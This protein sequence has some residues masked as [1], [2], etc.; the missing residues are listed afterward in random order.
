MSSA[1]ATVNTN[2]KTKIKPDT[3]LVVIKV[4]S[5]V[6]IL[7]FSLTCIIPFIMMV[8]GSFTSYHY[9][10]QHGFS[11]IPHDVSFYAYEFV[12]AVPDIIIGDYVLTIALTVIGTA[13][14]LFL[15]AMTGYVLQRPDYPFRNGISFYIYFTTLFSGGL[16][17]YFI[18]I[19]NYLHLKNNY[20]SILLPALLSPWLII[21][22]KSFLKSVPHAITEAAIIDGAGDFKIFTSVI[23]PVS[24]PAL[25][26]IGLFIGLGYWNDW[27]NGLLFLDNQVRYQ[28]LQLFLYKVVNMAQFLNTSAAML[29]IPPQN[30]PGDDLKMAVAV[31]ATGPIIIV[32]PFVQKYFI[33]GLT[34]GAVKG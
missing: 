16:V 29:N 28:P 7:I 23:L 3:S 22:M 18:L 24:K 27:Y 10:L 1:T 32:Y 19:V 17:P 31:V 8:S 14:G 15:T 25:A 13:V 2:K 5:V 20:L 21:M 34:I 30:L 9:I 12:F 33:K 26:T 4:I 11:L 6:I